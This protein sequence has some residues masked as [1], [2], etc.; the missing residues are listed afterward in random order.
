MAN[1][2]K[3]PIALKKE[4]HQLV[5][6]KNVPSGLICSCYCP[7][8]KQDL[9]AIT[10]KGKQR[11][12]FRHQ[13]DS[14]CRM[15]Y[16][17]FIHWVTKEVFKT[18][19]SIKL[20]P[21]HLSDVDRDSYAQF[22]QHMTEFLS[23]NNISIEGLDDDDLRSKQNIF[24][25]KLL[26]QNTSEAKIQTCYIENNYRSPY[27]DIRPDIVIIQNKQE[28]FVEPFLTNQVDE[29]K[30]LK[31]ND[32]DI[33]T[34]SIDLRALIENDRQDFT[35]DELTTFLVNNLTSKRWIYIRKAKIHSLLRKWFTQVLPQHVR[36]LKE[37][38]NSNVERLSGIVENQ[39][40]IKLLTEEILQLQSQNEAFISEIKEINIDDFLNDCC[41]N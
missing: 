16:E 23:I 2:I 20:P 12:H 34:I 31:I 29:N 6:A 7:E 33:T 30:H 11:A 9:I 18:L 40:R 26:L 1:E 38:S 4:D 25:G 27:G 13:Q 41:S 32:L 19:K 21:I 35:I 24:T 39:K 28:L 17:T 22:R 3:F 10:G 36:L 5:N 37:I 8:C 15:N 14:Q